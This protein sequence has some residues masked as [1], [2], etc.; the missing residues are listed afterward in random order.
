MFGYVSIDKPNIL[1]KDFHTYKAYYCGLCKVTGEHYSQ[2]MRLS[3]NYDIVLL[4]LLAHNYEKKEPKFVEGRCILRPIGKKFPIAVSKDILKRVV[5]INIILTYYKALDDV[6]DESCHKIIKKYLE[7]RYQKLKKEY[8]ELCQTVDNNYKRLRELEK[9]NCRSAEMLG[10]C[11]GEIM[12]SCAKALTKNAD[13]KLVSLCYNLGKWIYYIDALDDL[14]EDLKKKRFNP[15][16]D[17]ETCID[18][19]FFEKKEKY[20]R[21]LLY[22]SI[23]K[24]IEDYDKMDISISEGPL[25]NIIYLGLKK[26]TQEVLERRGN[27]CQKIRF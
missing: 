19:K 7:R 22:S 27:K 5:D 20:I 24:I 2:L 13:D 23:D 21:Y 14:K 17:E 26:K 18:E 25:S 4:S 9:N 15:F 10:E 1:F 6:I 16:I 12:A 11:F 3:V 8:Q